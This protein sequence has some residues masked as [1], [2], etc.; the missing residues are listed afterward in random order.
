MSWAVPPTNRARFLCVW[1]VFHILI[2]VFS[3][4][5]K[6]PPFL[7]KGDSQVLCNRWKG[8][9]LCTWLPRGTAVGA[10]V[11][12]THR[13]LAGPR[14]RSLPLLSG[15]FTPAQIGQ[16]CGTNPHPPPRMRRLIRVGV[17]LCPPEA[18]GPGAALDQRWAGVSGWLPQLRPS[19]GGMLG[20]VLQ[21]F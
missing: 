21:A 10:C 9:C 14:G 11:E 3:F 17:W 4:S 6:V 7:L 1:V 12:L 16:E 20:H 8:V 5:I 18:Q 13:A 19:A 15:Y 2:K